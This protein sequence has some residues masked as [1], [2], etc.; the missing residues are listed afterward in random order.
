[1]AAVRSI[2]ARAAK[3]IPGGGPSAMKRKHHS[4]SIHTLWILAQP[5]T[6]SIA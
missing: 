5:G 1:M 2:P 6:G 3:G 4:I